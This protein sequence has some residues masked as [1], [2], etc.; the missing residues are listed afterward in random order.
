[1]WGRPDHFPPNGQSQCHLFGGIGLDMSNRRL[2]R[3][4]MLQQ[5]LLWARTERECL[6]CEGKTNSLRFSASKVSSRY[7]ANTPIL[8]QRFQTSV[9]AVPRRRPSL[10][11]SQRPSRWR[12]RVRPPAL[13]RVVRP[14][15]QRA[16]PPSLP[17][18]SFATPV[19]DRPTCNAATHN[20]TKKPIRV[21]R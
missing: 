12:C 7:G 3:Q 20:A 10:P 2:C 6:D 18:V 21:N 16:S 14:R 13:R 11:K 1:M 9:S 17:P 5:Q 19:R 4:G 15:R 8:F